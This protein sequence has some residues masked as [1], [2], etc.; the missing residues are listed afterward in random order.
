MLE[1]NIKKYLREIQCDIM[2]WIHL[3]QNR[4]Q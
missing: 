1:Y 2:D 3:T 4:N